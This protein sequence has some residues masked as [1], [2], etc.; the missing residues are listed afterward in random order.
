MRLSAIWMAMEFQKLS[1]SIITM[2][3]YI[4]LMVKQGR[5]RT[6]RR[7]NTLKGTLV[8][9]MGSLRDFTITMKWLLPM[10]TGMATWRLFFPVWNS[11]NGVAAYDQQLGQTFLRA[12]ALA[13]NRE[14]S[15][16]P[17]STRTVGRKSMQGMC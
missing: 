9:P 15:E 6:A 3:R 7:S 4:F 17:I 12:K 14:I 16:L 10:S 5:L 1:L 2:I 13:P 11:L 8:W